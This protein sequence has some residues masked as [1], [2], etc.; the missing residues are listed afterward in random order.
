MESIDKLLTSIPLFLIL[1][2]SYYNNIVG[3]ILSFC[4]YIAVCFEFYYNLRKYNKN[5][6]NYILLGLIWFNSFIYTVIFYN[7]KIIYNIFI[8]CI[9]S[10]S[11]QLL[12]GK[13]LEKYFKY[14]PFKKISPNK[15]LIGYLGGM[16][17]T[18]IIIKIFLNFTSFTSFTI[19]V[20]YIFSI[21]GDLLA[22]KIKRN[23]D[24]KDYKIN[25]LA[26][27]GPHGGFLDRFDS[28][29]LSVPLYFLWI[30]YV[31]FS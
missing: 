14:K 18:F 15:T 13:C 4:V 5:I 28:I 19:I 17:L 27:L 9:V 11:T 31:K 3:Y 8:I 10:D 26:L 23:W 22:S 30:N 7:Y 16:I 29:I 20:I 25:N 12:T 21:L 1:Y 2:A 24:I 6:V